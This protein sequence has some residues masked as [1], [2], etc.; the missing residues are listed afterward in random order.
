MWGI[1]IK[2]PHKPSEMSFLKAIGLF[3]HIFRVVV[4]CLLLFS[5]TDTVLADQRTLGIAQDLANK[6]FAGFSYGSG[7]FDVKQIDCVQFILAVVTKRLGTVT[8]AMRQEILISYGWTSDETQ[9]YAEEGTDTRL[10]GVQKALVEAGKGVTVEKSDAQPGDIIQYWSKKTNG[11]WFG[12]A[13]VI[14]SVNS[15]TVTLFGAHQ[16]KKGIGQLEVNLDKLKL[17]YIVR[18]RPGD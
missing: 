12:H 2:R 11:V 3:F 8:P 14:Q 4:T 7:G 18:I 13:A 16:S 10:A 9:Q 6:D 15:G 5:F 1:Q 17:L